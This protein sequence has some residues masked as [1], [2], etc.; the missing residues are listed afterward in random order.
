MTLIFP[1]EG[2]SINRVHGVGGHAL[3]AADVPVPALF[4][5]E[6]VARRRHRTVGI[7]LGRRRPKGRAHVADVGVQRVFGD[8]RVEGERRLLAAVEVSDGH[9]QDAR[10]GVVGPIVHGDLSPVGERETDGAGDGLQAVWHVVADDGVHPPGGG[11]AVREGDA[12]AHRVTHVGGA[13]VAGGVLGDLG[14]GQV[15]PPGVVG[16]DGRRLDGIGGR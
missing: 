1:V 14:D 15:V 4:G 7:P 16:D 5:T 2:V 9:G 8:Q 12:V 6:G 13:V 3:V 10:G 11:A